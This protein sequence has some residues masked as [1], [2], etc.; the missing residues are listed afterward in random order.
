MQHEDT[1][2][3][4]KRSW[5]NWFEIPVSDF[6]RAQKFYE[7]V[8]KMKINAMDFGSFKM[9]IFPHKDVG[10]AIVQG[11][12]YN[13]G[14]QGATVYLNANPDLTDALGRV[15]SSG[16]EILQSKKQISPDHGYM[17]LFIDTEGNKVALHSDN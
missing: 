15:E 13:P 12:S 17:A 3:A 5:T 4:D 2:E 10:C 1:T 16:C 9:G 11:E 6:D 14:T 7:T 8:F